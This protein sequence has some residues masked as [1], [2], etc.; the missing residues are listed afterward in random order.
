VADDTIDPCCRNLATAYDIGQ[1]W[2]N[3]F[4][5]TGSTKTDEENG[6][7]WVVWSHDCTIMSHASVRVGYA[8]SAS[9]RW[10]R[11]GSA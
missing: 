11:W 1:K 7:K 8:G 5:R 3:V 4:R 9:C 6:I 2:A 10:V